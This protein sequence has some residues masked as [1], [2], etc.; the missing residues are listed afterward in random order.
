M[1]RSLRILHLY[2]DYAPVPGGIENHVRTLAKA[3][4]AAGHDVTVAVCA[5]Q[6]R[7]GE[8]RLPREEVMA[9]VRVLRL[10]RIVTLRSMPLSLPYWLAARRLARDSDV[11]HVQSP[12]PLGEAAVRNL[13][14][15]I[16]LIDSHQS[17]VVR[18]R[19]LLKFYAPLYRRFLCRANAILTTSDAYAAS[20]PW[21][22]PH[23]GKCH[24]VPL[25]VDTHRFRPV[26][27]PPNRT[28]PFRL[29][30]VGRLRYYK[31][32][33]T[34]LEAMATLPPSAVLDIVGTGPMEARWRAQARDRGLSDRVR[35][36]G[37]VPDATLPGTYGAA[38]LFVLPCN[39]RAEAFGTVL[40]EALACGVPC[41]TCEV[42]T[43][44]SSVVRDGMTGLVVPPSDP[45]ALGAAIASLMSDRDRLARMARA[46]RADA[47]VRLAQETMVRAILDIVAG[48]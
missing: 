48:D 14:P 46:A 4:A 16:R 41:V 29:L 33:D 36:L 2:K 25:G 5:P 9:G 40:A 47:T 13:P 8:A 24:T 15:G 43:G 34:L 44:T 1:N 3:E 28:G 17:D 38:D 31:G 32:V 10:P 21:L 12:F 23:L 37:D 30:F 19:I 26:D 7:R 45:A 39:C 27:R 6:R 20:S 11:V 35:F 42:G 22:R 18:Q